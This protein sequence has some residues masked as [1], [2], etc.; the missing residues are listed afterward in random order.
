[1]RPTP[2]PLPDWITGFRAPPYRNIYEICPGES[3]LFGTE[4][5]YGD[6]AAELLILAQDAGPADEFERL[7]DAGHERPFAH[8]EFRPGFPRYDPGAGRGGAGTNATIH[9]LAERV[10]CRKLYGSAMIGLCR[11]GDSYHGTLPSPTLVR[12]H[13]VRVLRW[14]VDPQQTPNLRA[15]ICLGNLAQ[16]FMRR[17]VRYGASHG[18]VPTLFATPHPAAHAQAGKE[19]LVLPAWREMAR[20]MGWAWRE[21]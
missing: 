7:R 19:R 14:I 15:V 21:S 13:C 9:A 17:A 20:T 6:W 5:L 12:E 4:S 2:S 10:A 18:R 3:W 1:V 16:D 11:P 8:R